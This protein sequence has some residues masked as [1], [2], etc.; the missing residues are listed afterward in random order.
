MFDRLVDQ[1]DS[2]IKISM[3]N[4]K[5]VQKKKKYTLEHSVLLTMRFENDKNAFTY[6]IMSFLSF[7]ITY[8]SR[9]C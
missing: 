2:K 4:V 5:C 8:F 3:C 6:R 7:F 9:T 1:F